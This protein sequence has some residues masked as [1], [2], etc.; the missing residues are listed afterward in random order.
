MA[1]VCRG[2]FMKMIATA[3]VTLFAAAALAQGT[4]HG[5][6]A[7]TTETAAPTAPS[8]A[9][10]TKET[11]TEHTTMEA[12]KDDTCTGKTGKAK[13][14]CEAKMKKAHKE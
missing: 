8:E 1:Q 9:T 12:K 2:E 13:A 3:L 14:K 10:M 11:T 4:G 7:E 6:T 5:T